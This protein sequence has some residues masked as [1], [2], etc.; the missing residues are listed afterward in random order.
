MLMCNKCWNRVIP[1]N[2]AGKP[3]PMPDCDG[4]TVMIDDDM[5]L[6]IRNLNLKGWYTQF[7]CSG[8]PLYGRY[9]RKTVLHVD[10][11]ERTCISFAERYDFPYLPEGFQWDEH[12]PFILQADIPAD[13]TEYVRQYTV[14]ENCKRLLAWS[15]AIEPNPNVKA[16]T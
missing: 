8:H 10:D 1:A 15:E 13:Q 6:I 9:R 14:W 16:G 3:C 4:S 11:V 7:C 12:V 2:H 5:A